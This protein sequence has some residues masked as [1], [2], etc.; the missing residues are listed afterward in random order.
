MHL[1][2]FLP[3]TKE[4]VNLWLFFVDPNNPTRN[5][6]DLNPSH[7]IVTSVNYIIKV[8]VTLKQSQQREATNKHHIHYQIAT[9]SCASKSFQFQASLHIPLG[10]F[11]IKPLFL[12]ETTQSFS[13]S[14]ALFL[15]SRIQARRSVIFSGMA[16]WA[17]VIIGVVLFVLLQPGLLFAFPGNSQQVEFARM[18]TNGKAIFFHT[19]FFF[20]L[21][22]V[23]L[24]VLR[25]RIYISGWKR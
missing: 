3:L 7:L 19:L 24:L 8:S 11:L 4:Q 9:H 6:T 15:I 14:S 13:E 23:L 2:L 22:S 16:D 5:Q 20:A 21:Y 1:S 25:I 18:K 10:V 17:P 12:L